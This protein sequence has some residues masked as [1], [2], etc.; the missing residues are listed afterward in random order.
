MASG[1]VVEGTK[2]AQNTIDQQSKAAVS[3][4]TEAIVRDLER[5]SF[6]AR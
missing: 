1:K 3:I 2:M 5:P 4:A 6:W